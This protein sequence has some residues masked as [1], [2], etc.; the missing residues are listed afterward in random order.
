M[1]IIAFILKIKKKNNNKTLTTTTKH[2]YCLQV[3]RDLRYRSQNM[4]RNINIFIYRLYIC[5]ETGIYLNPLFV[6]IL[7]NTV[8]TTVKTSIDHFDR[9]LNPL[10]V[11]GW[12]GA[13]LTASSL[14]AFLAF[15]PKYN[16][17]HSYLYINNFLGF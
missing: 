9:L 11:T 5:K 7:W 15:N 8:H 17:T 3:A 14:Q 16:W 6:N 1:S 13:S 4:K 10:L 12:A 2:I